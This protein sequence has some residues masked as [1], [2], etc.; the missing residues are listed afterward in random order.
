MLPF[1][2]IR[3]WIAQAI[4]V[5]FL[6]GEMH[7]CVDHQLTDE[8][9]QGL[10]VFAVLHGVIEVVDQGNQILVLIV[11]FFY[12]HTE[13]GLPIEKCHIGSC[14]DGWCGNQSRRTARLLM[15]FVK[16]Q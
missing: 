2:G 5:I 14:R 12:I 11:E 10:P 4:E 16:T 1:V 9:P 15:A 7:G 3:F 13:A 8:I 6:F